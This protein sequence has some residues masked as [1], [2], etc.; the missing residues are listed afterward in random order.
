[1][2]KHILVTGAAVLALGFSVGLASA[3]PFV[4]CPAT[5]QHPS[6]A[7]ATKSSLTQA[8]VSCNAPNSTADTGTTPTC[9]P[10]KTYNEANP[11]VGGWLW[12]AKSKGEISFKSGKNKVVNVLNTDPNAI[13]IYIAV[14]MSGIEDENGVADGSSGSVPSLARFTLISRLGP[15]PNGVMTVIDFPTGFGVTTSHGKINKKT[16][17]T[18]IL[19]GLGLAA[20]GP[21]GNIEI[22]DVKVKDPN[23]NNFATMGLFLP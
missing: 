1:M 11:G 14:K 8:F 18:V 4:P 5:Y 10:A 21:C 22:V 17:A 16:S 6:S 3:N 2:K 13:D 15:H 19:N 9:F 7:K 20:L 12:G 23:G